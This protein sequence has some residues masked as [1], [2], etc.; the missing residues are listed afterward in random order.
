MCIFGASLW[1]FSETVPKSEI[2][3]PLRIVSGHNMYVSNPMPRLAILVY[4]EQVAPAAAFVTA[5]DVAQRFQEA[6]NA[7]NRDVPVDSY[8]DVNDR[9]RG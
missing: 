8:R 7:I 2:T 1:V 3:G 4:N 9:L 6:Y 5:V